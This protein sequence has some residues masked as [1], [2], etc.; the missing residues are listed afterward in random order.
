M[1]MEIDG[2]EVES[3]SIY[4]DSL[5]FAIPP[6]LAFKV[7]EVL[8]LT[9]IFALKDSHPEELPSD[10][11]PH[12][13]TGEIEFAQRSIDVYHEMIFVMQTGEDVKALADE[14]ERGYDVNQFT[15]EGEKRARAIIKR[16]TPSPMQKLV[17]ERMTWRGANLPM[18]ASEVH[19][20]LKLYEEFEGLYVHSRSTVDDHLKAMLKKG[21]VRI[22]DEGKPRRWQRV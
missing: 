5:P 11:K 1:S 12:K 3:P 17:L 16:H 6:E 19:A 7:L 15:P 10:F 22:V 14:A 9:H 2:E 13:W 20:R 18:T 21:L 8:R 4:A